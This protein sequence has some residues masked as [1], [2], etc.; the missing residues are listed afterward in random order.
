MVV[1]IE[2]EEDDAMGYR[3]NVRTTTRIEVADEIQE[4]EEYTTTRG[5]VVMQ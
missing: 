2:L 4:E 1:L 5:V 3:Q